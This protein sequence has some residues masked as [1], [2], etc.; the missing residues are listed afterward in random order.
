MGWLLGSDYC[1]RN[2]GSKFMIGVIPLLPGVERYVLRDRFRDS[3]SDP[4]TWYAT[5]W[6]NESG[7]IIML[8]L[9]NEDE[10]NLTTLTTYRVPVLGYGRLFAEGGCIPPGL[11]GY[12]YELLDAYLTVGTTQDWIRVKR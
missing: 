8:T 11:V 4:D 5:M 1:I 12:A 2:I 3:S 9:S 10:D 6:R 7:S